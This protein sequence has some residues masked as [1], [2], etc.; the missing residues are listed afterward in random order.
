MRDSVARR[1]REL[2]RIA[3]S[4][5]RVAG[6]EADLHDLGIGRIEERRD[7][8]RALDVGRGVGMERRRDAAVARPQGG[9]LDSRGRPA[10]LIRRKRRLALRVGSAGRGEPDLVLVAGEHDRTAGP[11]RGQDLD[12]RVE[13]REVVEEPVLV[14]D[15]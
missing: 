3:A 15:A 5:D 4:H 12:R 2:N 14:G 1:S 9:E 8:L 7:L 13:E 11:G 10:Q 6:V